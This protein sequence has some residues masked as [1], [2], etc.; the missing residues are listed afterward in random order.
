MI[1]DFLSL[2][3]AQAQ[4]FRNAFA[5]FGVDQP[6]GDYEL[7]E[8]LRSEG[9]VFASSGEEESECSS[10]DFGLPVLIDSSYSRDR[11][12]R[13]YRGR[14]RQRGRGGGPNRSCGRDY[15]GRNEVLAGEHISPSNRGHNFRGVVYRESNR[16]RGNP[17]LERGR[18]PQRNSGRD[19]RR[20]RAGRHGSQETCT[21]SGNARGSTLCPH[22]VRESGSTIE[23]QIDTRSTGQH[24]ESREEF[25]QRM[26]REAPGI[27]A[28]G[29]SGR[30][31]ELDR[32]IDW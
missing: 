4:I 7:T 16:G 21:P 5:E 8:S 10:D 28:R 9:F 25:I 1:M 12:G 18:G 2:S 31:V 29:R 22:D 17:A 30:A 3:A 27:L 19:G 11:V 14:R 23:S 6:F 24:R 15:Q 13:R 26:I 20:G 32:D